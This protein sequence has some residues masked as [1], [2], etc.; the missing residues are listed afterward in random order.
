MGASAADGILHSSPAMQPPG[1]TGAAGFG[2]FLLTES[3]Y[4]LIL[5]MALGGIGYSSFVGQPILGY[6]LLLAPAFAV[7]CVIGGLRHT[8]STHEV[9][10]LVWTQVLQWSA[11]VLAMYVL[12]VAPFRVA[13]S[14][15]AT[16][17][18]QLMMLALGT[19]VSGV[20]TRSWR[21]GLVGIILLLAVPVVSWIEL[22]STLFVLGLGIILLVVLGLFWIVERRISKRAATQT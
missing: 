4:I 1:R 10:D 6:W 17:L 7:L 19:F 14:G 9:V 22:S 16:A 11:F 13:V 3:P 15:N 8:H 5:I 21:I 20:N 2:R 12:T 18:L